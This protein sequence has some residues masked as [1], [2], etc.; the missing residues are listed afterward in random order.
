MFQMTD[1]MSDSGTKLSIFHF[2]LIEIDQVSKQPLY[3]P[4]IAAVALRYKRGPP[5]C[6]KEPTFEW[7]WHALLCARQTSGFFYREL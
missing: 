5:T 3:K 2:F 7:W 1:C 4:Y 6:V